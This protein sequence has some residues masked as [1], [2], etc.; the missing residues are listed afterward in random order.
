MPTTF[1]ELQTLTVGLTRRPEIPA[2]TNLAIRTAVLRAHHTDFF[3]RDLVSAEHSYSL[4]PGSPYV[5]IVSLSG[6][7]PRLRSLNTVRGLDPNTQLEVEELDYR[8]VD[9]IYDSDGSQRPSIFNLIGDT[10]R[11]YPQ[12]AT[13]RLRIS[14]FR[15]PDV[16]E[17]TFNSWI[18]DLYPDQ[19]AEWAASI[20]YARTGFQ[21]QA[22]NTQDNAVV[23][24]K[25]LLISS[26]LLGAVK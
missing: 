24:F 25:E 18:A 21:E 6:I 10:L 16:S 19:I 5:D 17:A 26:H 23:P 12:W 15:N 9:D 3:P 7:L 4:V 2:V 22:K 1:A 20:V 8:D 14:Y 13:G 11:I